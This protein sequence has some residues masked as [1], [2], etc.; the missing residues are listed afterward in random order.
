MSK[1]QR[2]ALI[3]MFGH[4][5]FSIVG[6]VTEQRVAMEKALTAVPLPDDVTTS[7]GELG[8]V[9]IVNINTEV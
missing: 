5:P 9:P 2:L 1:K 7:P 8:G 4:L 3:E 6:E